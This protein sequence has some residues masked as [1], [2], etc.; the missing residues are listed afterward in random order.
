[1]KIKG[2]ILG[3]LLACAIGI[4]VPLYS[5]YMQENVTAQEAYKIGKE[6]LMQTTREENPNIGMSDLGAVWYRYGQSGKVS[7]C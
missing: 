7:R 5:L 4:S 6:I 1:M 2:I 3:V